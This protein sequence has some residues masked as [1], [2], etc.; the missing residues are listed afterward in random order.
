MLV[1][2]ELS[3]GLRAQAI[4]DSMIEG[5]SGL[6]P[7]T[8]HDREMIE[9]GSAVYRVRV[10]EGKGRNQVTV[11]RG[12]SSTQPY[13]GSHSEQEELD[14]KKD[15]DLQFTSS[16]SDALQNASS[17]M[18]KPD[19]IVQA[20]TQRWASGRK[21]LGLLY[22]DSV[23][24]Q[25]YIQFSPGSLFL[26]NFQ[27]KLVKLPIEVFY[28]WEYYSRPLPSSLSDQRPDWSYRKEVA[29]AIRDMIL[30]VSELFPL[31]GED[32]DLIGM[33][34]SEIGLKFAYGFWQLAAAFITESGNIRTGLKYNS[35]EEDDGC[36]GIQH[37]TK[38]GRANMDA[39][40]AAIKKARRMYPGEQLKTIVTV[41]HATNNHVH[42]G[43]NIKLVS[44]CALCRKSLLQ[45]SPNINAIIPLNG[46]GLGKVPMRVLYPLPDFS[47]PA[48]PLLVAV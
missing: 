4:L 42:E 44:S 37:D 19:R 29:D 46:Q 16:W 31:T 11:V 22:P 27:R 23:A 39:E 8:D 17:R 30:Q 6:F 9:F 7:V 47:V 10:G 14:A 33:A 15:P 2:S 41:H 28:P 3:P 26:V 24:R 36:I 21:K 18:K 38:S 1:A 12:T 48:I 43:G 20:A 34:K 25:Q 13:I 5:V 35:D 40:Q 32:H 45:Y